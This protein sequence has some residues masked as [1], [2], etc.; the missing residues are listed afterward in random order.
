MEISETSYEAVNLR[1]NEPIEGVCVQHWG[2]DWK[3]QFQA[4]FLSLIEHCFAYRDEPKEYGDMRGG[5]DEKGPN[6]IPV[7]V[8]G[9]DWTIVNDG[10]RYVV[11]PDDRGDCGPYPLGILM[12]EM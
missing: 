9:R 3:V 1:Q 12:G 2:R 11:Y 5:N 4:E 6:V 7:T 10:G 8:G